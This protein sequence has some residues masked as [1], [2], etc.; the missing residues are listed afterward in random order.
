MLNKCWSGEKDS[1]FKNRI[2]ALYK[3]YRKQNQGNVKKTWDGIRN[4]IVAKKKNTPPIKLIYKNKENTSNIEMAESLIDFFVNI[5]SS[6]EAKIPKSKRSFVSYLGDSNH[7]C[8]FLLPCSPTE[9]LLTINDMK[10]SKA[11]GPNSITSNLLMEF[12]QF[13][14]YPLVSIINMSLKGGIFPSM[15]KEA[16]VCPIHKKM[17][18]ASVEI[19]DLFHFSQILVKFLNELCTHA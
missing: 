11:S 12:S 7:K 2:L 14:V 19:I 10:S 9:I 13:L 18:K 3:R 8:I 17:K 16:D 5:G 1:Q 15:N 4:L 6:V